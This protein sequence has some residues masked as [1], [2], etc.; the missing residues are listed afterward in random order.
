MSSFTFLFL[1]IQACLIQN[2]LTTL[3]GPAVYGNGF[4]L[5]NSVG[6]GLTA[7]SAELAGWYG[8]DSPASYNGPRA[9]ER[10][11]A[12]EYAYGARAMERDM[13]AAYGARAVE[14]EMAAEYGMARNAAMWN[15]P[16]LVPA[17]MAYESGIGAYGGEGIGDVAVA[18][19]MPVAG[20][21]MV[22]G[23]VPILGAVRFA[24]DLPAGGVVTIAGSS[25]CGNRYI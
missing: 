1:C 19:E 12:A 15:A 3:I 11:M 2:G 23:Q 5:G 8:C 10:E 18:G 9:L 13:A 14:R 7:A 24:G 16:A 6:A 4:G 25:G 17:P 20:T 22:A 21:T